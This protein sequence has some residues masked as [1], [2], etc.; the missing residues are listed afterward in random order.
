MVDV[1]HSLKGDLQIRVDNSKSKLRTRVT[2]TDTDFKTN[3]KNYGAMLLKCYLESVSPANMV[4]ETTWSYDTEELHVNNGFGPLK[5]FPR[6][7][8]VDRVAAT[9][10][11]DFLLTLRDDG[12][13]LVCVCSETAV[14][15]QSPSRAVRS[16]PD[17]VAL[18]NRGALTGGSLPSISSLTPNLF[19][20]H[21]FIEA[22]AYTYPIHSVGSAYYFRISDS[23]TAEAATYPDLA[24]IRR[25]VTTEDRNGV[26]VKTTVTYDQ[27][28]DLRPTKTF[29]TTYGLH[30]FSTYSH[31]EDMAIAH[32]PV[33][34]YQNVYSITTK[35]VHEHP[36]TKT[37]TTLIETEIHKKYDS[38]IKINVNRREAD[39]IDVHIDSPS[40]V[41][42]ITEVF[43]GDKQFER[44]P[45]C[46]I[47]V[48]LI[49][50][51][52]Y[53]HCT[54]KHKNFPAD[55][56]NIKACEV[57]RWI[58]R[59]HGPES[60]PIRHEKTSYLRTFSIY[61]KWML[62]RDV[63]NSK[64]L[65]LRVRSLRNEQDFNSQNPA[66]YD[67]F[68]S[69]LFDGPCT[70]KKASRLGLVRPVVTDTGRRIQHT[71]T[72]NGV[73]D[74]DQY[75][76]V[77]TGDKKYVCLHDKGDVGLNVAEGVACIE[78]KRE[79]VY[80]DGNVRCKV[81]RLTVQLDIS[82][83]G[84]RSCRIRRHR[85]QDE[86]VVAGGKDH[87][88]K[89]QEHWFKPGHEHKDRSETNVDGSRRAFTPSAQTSDR[90]PII[91]NF[92][93]GKVTKGATET[94]AIDKQA[95]GVMDMAEYRRYK[96]READDRLL[97][98][99]FPT[100]SEEPPLTFHVAIPVMVGAFILLL[101]ALLTVV[102]QRRRLRAKKRYKTKK[103]VGY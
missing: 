90:V 40:G 13:D 6:A 96:N 23:N 49:R 86:V 51:N 88:R 43:V 20:K 74:A 5:Y 54:G 22:T 8:D 10:Y 44:N 19:V 52:N 93:T 79:M 25:V 103:T 41:L 65:M 46:T 71:C 30:K 76:V 72:F 36:T 9:Y 62:P 38:S 61:L 89:H 98:D 91:I 84:Y 7:P 85:A 83:M 1:T 35:L 47:R 78:E 16:S 75:V 97:R 11:T 67:L 81:H 15:L 17:M 21:L 60:K 56:G 26:V 92:V 68:H 102:F 3:G 42:F 50:R 31:R 59:L 87:H 95:T 37:R 80:K 28:L 99:T 45:R 73:L 69:P 27:P 94:S 64:D 82:V 32:I 4:S 66:D 39:V 2:C 100:E 33:I 24:N 29:F 53:N 101:C 14:T 77:I 18:T 63:A 57:H 34:F 12:P 55:C 70:Y 48:H 58:A